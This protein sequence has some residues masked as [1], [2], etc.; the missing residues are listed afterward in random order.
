MR[1]T[2]KET[3][4][5]SAKW[6]IDKNP[7]AAMRRV[8]DSPNPERAMDELLELSKQDK[9]GKTKKGLRVALGQL[10]ES[11]R[12]RGGARLSKQIL[13]SNDF[14]ISFGKLNSLLNHGPTKKA[15]SKLYSPKEMATLKS[16][17]EKMKVMDRVNLQVSAGSPTAI[18]EESVRS[19][20]V[21]AFSLFGI[22]RGRGI[23]MV[24]RKIQEML[25]AD[26][27]EKAWKLLTDSMLDPKLAETLLT[28]VNNKTLPIV[29]SK[30]A[31]Y[32]ANNMVTGE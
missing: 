16:L 3:N 25:G 13:N 20:Q 22:V 10:I 7:S 28:N 18:L 26:P 6:F 30:L 11:P 14:E 8:I 23:F 9:S 12:E 2:E 4:L 32:M 15:I 21:L 27:V 17:H 29:K 19:G 1:Q 5:N 31:T 24:S